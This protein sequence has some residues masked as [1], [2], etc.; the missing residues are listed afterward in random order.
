[1][2]VR[3]DG[4]VAE[5]TAYPHGDWAWKLLHATAVDAASRATFECRGCTQQST[6]HTMAFVFSLN[7][8]DSSGNPMPTVWKQVGDSSSE[9]MVFG[10]VHVINVGPSSEPFH[11]RAA[12]CL[13]LWR[14]SKQAGVI[15]R[16]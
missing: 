2:G 10:P 11:K 13:W 6:A 9:V 8:F 5:V 3:L 16:K 7:R 4:T 1:V 12:R 14:C 15:P